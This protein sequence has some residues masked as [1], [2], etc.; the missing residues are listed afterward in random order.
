MP[1]RIGFELALKSEII[2]CPVASA[3]WGAGFIKTVRLVSK[4]FGKTRPYDAIKYA[5]SIQ[6]DM[7]S[8]IDIFNLH[9]IVYF[10][11]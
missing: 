3:S 11:I 5:S 1:P 9:Y 7:I 4:V 2:S 6:A 8:P 10:I